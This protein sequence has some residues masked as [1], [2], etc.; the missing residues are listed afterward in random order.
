MLKP[1][2]ENSFSFKAKSNCVN[3]TWSNLQ[4]NCIRIRTKLRYK[5]QFLCW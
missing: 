3:S 2:W 4:C 5:D 1:F